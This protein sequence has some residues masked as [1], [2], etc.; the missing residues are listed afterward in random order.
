MAL[1]DSFEIELK[2]LMRQ[3]YSFDVAF[4]R[5]KENYK[6][7]ADQ[8]DQLLMIKQKIARDLRRE[9]LSKEKSSSYLNSHKTHE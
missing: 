4:Q 9:Y 1:H 3:G 7:L 5:I 2:N 8:A 6:D